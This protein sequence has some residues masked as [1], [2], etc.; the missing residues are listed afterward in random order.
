MKFVCKTAELSTACQNVQRAVSAKSSIPGAE[1]IF[2]KAL[3][4]ELIL[5]GYDLEIGINTSIYA[6]IEE[7]GSIVLNA[8]V[9]CE[10]LR[11]IPNQTITVECD[12]RNL[13]VIR[14][15]DIKYEIMG[16]SGDEYPELPTVQ[17][18]FSVVIDKNLLKEMV[19]QTIFAVAVTDANVVYKGI[20]FELTDGEIKLIAVDGFRMAIRTEKI[21]YHGEDI[22]FI[23]PA[24]TMAEVVK[25]AVTDEEE[26]NGGFISISVGKR[27]IFFEVDGYSVISRLLEGEFIN[28]KSTIPLTTTTKIEVDTRSFIESIERTSLIITDK[29]KSL[30]NCVFDTDFIRVSSITAL[31]TASDKVPA[32]VEGSR[33]EIGFNNRYLLDA[34]KACDCDRVKIELNGPISPILILPVEGDDFIFLVLPV[35]LKKND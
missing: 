31:G 19:R 15:G 32:D 17:S 8:K 33:V 28:Y 2:I 23:V 22:T 35:R 27:H 5:T 30:I 20:K 11:K 6:N 12:E 21:D 29:T 25:L 7:A 14:S 4:N 9:L 1:G 10:I 26:E 24:K 3:N 34:L 18:G 13:A 16:I